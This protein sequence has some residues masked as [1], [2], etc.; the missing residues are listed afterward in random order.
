MSLRA[1]D[2]REIVGATRMALLAII[3]GLTSGFLLPSMAPTPRRVVAPRMQSSEDS[4]KAAWLARLDA[5]AWGHENGVS[6]YTVPAAANVAQDTNGWLIQGA[7]VLSLE[8]A[9]E[10]S[11]VALR[12]AA[13]RGFKP[14]SVIVLDAAGRTLVSKTMIGAMGL[15]PEFGYAKASA[16]LGMLCSSRELGAKYVNA[17]GIGPKMPQALNMA[18]IGAATNKAIA[19]FPG[20]VLCRDAASNVVCAIAVSGA[21]SDEDEHCA[22]LAA[23]SVGLVTDPPFSRLA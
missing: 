6:P 22:I 5:P 14:V 17:D 11:N 4:A 3:A 23:R 15:A 12:E 16:C 18:L 8:A 9:D 13:S 2:L 21:S 10:M 19:I 1:E 7:P 20:G